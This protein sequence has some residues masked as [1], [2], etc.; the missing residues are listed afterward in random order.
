MDNKNIL[1]RDCQHSIII[2]TE[3]WDLGGR[4]FI[5]PEVQ[6]LM[7]T[8]NLLFMEVLEE[9]KGISNHTALGR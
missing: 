3:M 7:P 6:A 9:Q 2:K 8:A 5:A 4:R 1:L